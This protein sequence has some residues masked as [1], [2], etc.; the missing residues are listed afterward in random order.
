M[1]AP[2]REPDDDGPSKDGPL[3]Y[4]PRRV[5]R[6][7]RDTNSGPRKRGPV[8]TARGSDAVDAP[9]KVDAVPQGAAE[10][11]EPPWKR[12]KQRQA[13]AGDVA[14][15]ELRTRLALAPDRLPDPPPPVSTV[16]KFGSAA[17]LAGVIMVATAGVVGYRWGAAPN[18]P[19]PLKQF[20]LT[21]DQAGLAAERSVLAAQ[22]PT[23]TLRSKPVGGA[24]ASGDA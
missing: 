13:F 12:K 1:S 24:P 16:P 7:E 21:S 10:L 14:A 6:P 4:A 11:P 23:P 17:R 2:V 15:A 3:D 18:T 22:L 9:R 8:D 20:E 19:T 5:R